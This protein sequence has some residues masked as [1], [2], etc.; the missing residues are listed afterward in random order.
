MD[1]AVDR[2][3]A[4]WKTKGAGIKTEE[5]ARQF[6]LSALQK[7][8]SS[9]SKKKPSKVNKSMISSPKD[10]QHL[11]HVGWT[12]NG[13]DVRCPLVPPSLCLWLALSCFFVCLLVYINNALLVQA[14][15][16]REDW[17]T[18][19]N[20]AGIDEDLLQ[21]RETAEFISQFIKEQ[22]GLDGVV[23]E[24]DDPATFQIASSSPVPAAAGAGAA[25][26]ASPPAMSSPQTMTRQEYVQRQQLSEDAKAAKAAK[27]PASTGFFNFG[28]KEAK[29]VPKTD[30]T[31]IDPVIVALQ[32][33]IERKGFQWDEARKRADDLTKDRGM[34][35][36]L[37]PHPVFIIFYSILDQLT[38]ERDFLASRARSAEDTVAVLMSKIEG[39]KTQRQPK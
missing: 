20:K 27:K 25:G 6:F 8:S 14:S 28:K 16:I 39:T 34:F 11:S 1:K 19:L 32:N 13:Y 21:D 24:D 22:G 12:E 7:P 23:D 9:S 31:Y 35:S 37:H 38:M 36:F 29:F 10:F 3:V 5:E 2:L 30:P 26:N 15:N 4:E 18:L 17:R 33:E